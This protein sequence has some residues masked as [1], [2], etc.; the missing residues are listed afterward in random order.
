MSFSL[1]IRKYIVDQNIVKIQ[2]PEEENAQKIKKS[3]IFP[4]RGFRGPEGSTN[5]AYSRCF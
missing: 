5:L 1:I 4:S 2:F 3:W